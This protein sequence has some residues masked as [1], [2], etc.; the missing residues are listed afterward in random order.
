VRWFAALAC[1]ALCA[2]ACGLPGQSQAPS[3]S[4]MLA[5]RLAAFAAA[6]TVVMA[7]HVSF[8]G[9]SYPVSLQLDDQ[10]QASGSVELEHI[11]V[12]ATFVGGHAF[13]Q[14]SAYYTAHSLATANQWVLEREG[15]V[16]DLLTR[17]A[18]RKGLAAALRAAAGS[19]VRQG[20]GADAAGVKT[21]KLETTDVSAT[22]PASGG[23]PSRVVTGL[24]TQLSDGFS[25]VLLD[26]SDYG[27]PAGIAAPSAFLDRAQPDTWPAYYTAVIAPD[28]P[29]SFEPCDR[30]GCTLS[31]SFKNFGGKVGTAT[32]TFYV[33][34][35]GNL[36]GTCDV[37]IPATSNG[38]LVR[39]GCRISYD[40]SQSVSG[41][42]KVRN[43]Q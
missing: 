27:K 18:D 5:T 33:T 31:A 38:T 19:D 25:D 34:V 10:G 13:L 41:N 3:P 15:V 40:N 42:V 20:S 30:S 37:P 11:L 2:A 4:Q 1:A 32:A 6:K 36:L 26:L 9:V 35:S 23:P 28:T 43:P 24:D 21:T 17:L 8:R 7:G 16:V 39:A 22:V 29:F 14:N 12:S